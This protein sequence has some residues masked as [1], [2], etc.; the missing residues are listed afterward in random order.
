MKRQKYRS[1]LILVFLLV[2]A[3]WTLVILRAAQ[4][5]I[6]P[7]SKLAELKKR[8]YRSIVE[9]PARRGVIADR[10]GKELA[11]TVPSYSIFADPSEIEKPKATSRLLAKKLGL[12]QPVVYEKIR[13]D[14]K[15]FAWIRRHLSKD[16]ADEIK[17]LHIRGIGTVEESLRVYPNERLL[18]QSI[19][20]VGEEG[21]G[22]E[23]LELKYDSVMK[24]QSRKIKIE[25]DARGRP[26][27]EDGRL[28]TDTPAGF[29]L[30]LTIDA[31]LQYKLEKDLADAVTHHLADSAMG[32]ILDAHT[33]EILAM[34]NA[35]TFDPNRRHD[36][37]P[38]TTRN[39]VVTDAYEPGS[40]IKA[41][42]I[43]GALRENTTKPNK[44]Y[45]CEN[46]EF[47]VDN[48][49]IHEAD[50][51]H[52]FGWL[53]TSEILM[54][55]SNIGATKIA[56]ELGDA[57]VRKIFADFGLGDRLGVDL[58]GE[59]RG[60]LHPLP[61]RN[62]LLSNISFGHG[63]TATPLQIA[64]AYAAIAN[65]GW[66]REPHILKSMTNQEL[67]EHKEIGAKDIRRVLTSEQAATMRLM[68]NATTSETGTGFSA[69]VPGFP[70]AGKTGT[71]QK[72]QVGRGYAKG[73][74][75]SSFAGFIPA[76]D[77]RYVIYVA[78]DNP[79]NQYYGGEVAA[80]LFS[81]VASYAVRQAGLA[82]VLLSEKSVVRE[83][84]TT[85]ESHTRERSIAK[86]REMAKVL[87]EDD[88]NVTPDFSGLTLREVINRVRGTPIHIETSGRGVVSTTFP[89]AG[90]PL[91][92]S[93]MVRVYL[94]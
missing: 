76:N 74:Y 24:G 61:W 15:R 56:F 9:L 75:I 71:A 8:Q 7:N 39:R 57:R 64:S 48:R 46:G 16:A 81:K 55:S 80:P 13:N 90:Q 27:L 21:N 58:P 23:G 41:I 25:K 79:R 1:R 82:P 3:G 89:P 86:I 60:V 14:E 29:D 51:H 37:S 85:D 78:I 59:S 73:Q 93:K 53:T 12:L 43:A 11:V 50:A 6:L 91:P 70:V 28:F 4:L 20:F 92:P 54:H 49:V 40:T 83:I 65:G 66:L 77:P 19:G 63:M 26:L 84:K 31:D 69:R 18:S 42:L 44:K 45:F 34:A 88:K 72:I 68:L 36:T 10:N 35:P 87:D 67:G 32:V 30:Q 22:L 5:Q 52:R 2:V 33:S 94:Q 38:D 47:K 62:H 17:A